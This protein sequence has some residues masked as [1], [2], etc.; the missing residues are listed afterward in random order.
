MIERSDEGTFGFAGVFLPNRGR[1]GFLFSRFCFCFGVS[2][3]MRGLV[4][5]PV[6][7]PP[8]LF[9]VK[10][11]TQKSAVFHLDVVMIDCEVC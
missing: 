8:F 4:I 7:L 1:L 11:Q 9:P 10:A 3:R 6:D 5:E 2:W